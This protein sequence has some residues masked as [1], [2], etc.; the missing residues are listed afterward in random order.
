MKLKELEWII[1]LFCTMAVVAACTSNS[2]VDVSTSLPTKTPVTAVVPSF[3]PTRT[4]T[5]SPTAA[6][7]PTPSPVP[8]SPPTPTAT[9]DPAAF[10]RVPGEDGRIFVISDEELQEHDIRLE[11][12]EALREAI[13]MEY[14]GWAEYSQQLTFG[15]MVVTEDLAR[16][17]L[18][19]GYPCI[20]GPCPYQISVNPVV[21]LTVMTTQYGDEPPPGFDAWQTARQIAR[22]IKRLYEESRE[23]PEVWQ[24]NFANA[25]SFA[26]Y[27]MLEQDKDRLGA[28]CVTYHTFYALT[29]QPR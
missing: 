4:I 15:E 19:A 3:S 2:S 24:N 21:I 8:T 18:D 26:M 1:L 14:P 9:P 22:D 27:Q 7:T 6:S 16:I 11:A 10:C 13:R 29:Q 23:R 17:L 25:S 20:A 12:E 5:S 28:W